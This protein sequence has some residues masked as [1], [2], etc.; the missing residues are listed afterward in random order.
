MARLAS[1]NFR[2]SPSTLLPTGLSDVAI[3]VLSD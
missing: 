1:T 3:G 2:R